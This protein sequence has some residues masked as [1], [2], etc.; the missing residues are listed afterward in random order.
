MVRRGFED[1]VE[2]AGVGNR[3]E[4]NYFQGGREGRSE[5]AGLH[6]HGKII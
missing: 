1:A 2:Y 3:V 5:D 4:R 6:R